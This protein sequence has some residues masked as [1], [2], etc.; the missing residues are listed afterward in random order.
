M[1]PLAIFAIVSLDFQRPDRAGPDRDPSRPARQ[2]AAEHQSVED[3]PGGHQRRRR[4]L[5]RT[6]IAGLGGRI[7]QTVGGDSR[8]R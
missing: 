5:P 4:A 6:A 1:F 3:V 8:R 7:A 2:S